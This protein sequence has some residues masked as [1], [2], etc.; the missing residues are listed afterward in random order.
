MEAIERL[1]CVIEDDAGVGREVVAAGAWKPIARDLRRVIR[2]S[3]LA[4]DAKAAVKRSLSSPIGL[5]LE[6]RIRRVIVLQPGGW[7]S[8]DGVLAD[9]LSTMIKARNDLVHGRLPTDY[10][11]L[12]GAL[13]RAQATFQVM[14]LNFLGCRTIRR[15]GWADMAMSARAAGSD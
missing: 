4:E 5:T 3:N 13:L 2:D 14:F 6:D 10:T 12:Q 11:Q 8:P 9:G 15:E 7:A 1:I